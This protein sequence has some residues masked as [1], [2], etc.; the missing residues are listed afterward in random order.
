MKIARFLLGLFLVFVALV[1]AHADD[2]GFSEDFQKYVDE[3]SMPGAVR[4]RLKF[5]RPT[6]LDGLTLPLKDQWTKTFNF[7]L[8]PIRKQL[9]P[10]P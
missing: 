1:P 9:S 6:P 7:G 8:R 3:G 10:S 2:F 5:S 4:L